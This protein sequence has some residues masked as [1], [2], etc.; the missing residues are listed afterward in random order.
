MHKETLKLVY[1]NI[2]SWIISGSLFTVLFVFML[3]ARE[4]LFFKPFFAFQ[5]PVDWI[6]SFVLIIIVSGL[7]ALVTSLS[8]FQMRTVKVN[9]RKTG[10][11]VVGSVIGVGAGICTGCGQI[12]FTIISTL[13]GCRSYF[14]IVSNRI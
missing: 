13:G 12:G 4:F 14:L 3:Y 8:V 7:I 5:L 9:S 1:S 11:G 10:T 2:T 6:L